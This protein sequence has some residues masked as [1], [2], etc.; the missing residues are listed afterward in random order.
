MELRDFV[1]ILTRRKWLVA[2]AAAVVVA[3]LV[4]GLIMLPSG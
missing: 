2:A 4:A 3:T 1:A